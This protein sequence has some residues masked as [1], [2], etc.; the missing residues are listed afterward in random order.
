VDGVPAAL[1]ATAIEAADAIYVLRNGRQTV[2]R[3]AGTGFDE[4]EF[5]DGDGRIKAPMHGKVL[6][7]LVANGDRVKKGQR[8]AVIEAMKMEHALTAPR[9]GRVAEIAVEAGSQVA[10]GARLMTVEQVDE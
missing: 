9:A 1:D 4:L 7:L 2:V 10:E 3:R 8:L 5:G 6:A